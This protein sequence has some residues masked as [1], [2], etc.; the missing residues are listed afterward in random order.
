MTDLSLNMIMI[1]TITAA[2]QLFVERSN[3]SV[4]LFELSAG[5]EL[6]TR[7]RR[8]LFPLGFKNWTQFAVVNELLN[9]PNPGA[10]RNR[11]NRL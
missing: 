3:L 2:I 4:V 8:P 10:R 5:Q 7:V 1:L 6:T 11:T 9:T